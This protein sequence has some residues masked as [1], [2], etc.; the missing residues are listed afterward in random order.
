MSHLLVLFFFRKSIIY[1]L[2]LYCL[3]SILIIFNHII[4]F[5]ILLLEEVIE[6]TW[7]TVDRWAGSGQSKA[8]HLLPF[9]WHVCSALWSHTRSCLKGAAMWDWDQLD[10]ILDWTQLRPL[11]T[12]LRF[13]GWVWR[14]W[15]YLP[16]SWPKEASYVSS[17]AF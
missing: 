12:L 15:R 3:S 17:F 9:P 1:F 6:K 11:C 2:G 7:L 16:W 8:S 14:F 10:H 13:C 5:L 4:F